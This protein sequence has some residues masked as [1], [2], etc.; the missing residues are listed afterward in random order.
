MENDTE[1]AAIK[2]LMEKYNEYKSKWV[3]EYG[4]ETGFDQWFTEQ[5]KKS[6]RGARHD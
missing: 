1:A 4:T 2:E 3:E 5:V 6:S